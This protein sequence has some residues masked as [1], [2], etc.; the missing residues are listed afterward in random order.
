MQTREKELLEWK[1][2]LSIIETKYAVAEAKRKE[3]YQKLG[4]AGF[5]SM[6]ELEETIEMRKKETE[7]LNA[8]VDSILA[9]LEEKY[10]K[11]L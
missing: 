6:E 9:Y 8:K 4:A 2:K 1:E 10:G 11:Y 7:E 5:D 3:A